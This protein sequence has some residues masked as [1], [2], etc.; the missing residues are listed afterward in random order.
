[1]QEWEKNPLLLVK[2]SDGKLTPVT[3]PTISNSLQIHLDLIGSETDGIV[4]LRARE[5][6]IPIDL[7]GEIV[8][9]AEDYFEPLKAKEGKLTLKVGEHYLLSSTEVLKI[10]SQL[11][12]ELG[13][14]SHVGLSGPLHRAG[15]I[16]NGFEGD[17]VLEVTSHEP[18]NISVKH[19]TPIGELRLFR[20]RHPD[21]IYGKEIGSHYQQQKGPRTAK[22][23]IPF[24]FS[25]A[26]KNHAKL[27]KTVM[28]QDKRILLTHRKGTNGFER[29]TDDQAKELFE[30]IEKNGFFHSRYDCETDTDVLQVIPYTIVFD[31]NKNV[32]SYVRASDIRHYGDKRLFGKHSIG[33][34]GHILKRDAPNY[35]LN[36]LEREVSDEEVNFTEE[37]SK[38]V[39]LG[40]I[41]QP[42]L[43]VDKVHFGIVYGI[44]T[45]GNIIPKEQSIPR[46]K[47]VGI[48]SLIDDP[49]RFSNFE[50]WSRILIPHLE[51]LYNLSKPN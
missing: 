31:N 46:G 10:P 27:E 16:D 13:S 38:P 12:A 15:F 45:K 41:Y 48:D 8:R 21:K 36:C 5:N 7:T 50:T 9:P 39:L 43:P 4:G 37:R 22:Y 6:S 20:T 34:G 42:N 51:D 2:G 1:M 35:I 26:A 17:L 3:Q 24:D 14:H 19:G 49:N 23:F 29:I 40:T 47:M 25:N 28:V 30:A 44:H 32:F 33:L 18:S 11:N